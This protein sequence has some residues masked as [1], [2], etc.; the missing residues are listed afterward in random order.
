MIGGRT[1]TSIQWRINHPSEVTKAVVRR[2]TEEV[3]GGGNLD[4]FDEL[5]AD[6]FLDHTPQPGRKPDKAGAREL[7]R[8]PCAAFPDL[9]ADIHRQI[10]DSD[11]VAAS[12]VRSEQRPLRHLICSR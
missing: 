12:T 9:H 1:E 6:D 8:A 11:R 3:Q 10:A 5:F 2:N 4:V 7:N